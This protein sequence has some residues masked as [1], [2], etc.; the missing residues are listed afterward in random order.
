MWQYK[1]SVIRVVDA[2]TV[3]L[4]VDQGFRRYAIERFRLFG[5][6]APERGQVGWSEGKQALELRLPV[7]AQVVIETYHPKERDERDSFGR[8]L[9]TIYT[10]EGINL[11]QWLVSEGHAKV[12][13]R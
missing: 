4:L 3:D 7:D 11:N 6:D 13:E 12:Y 2:D 1:A 5:I 8:W 9:A 10:A